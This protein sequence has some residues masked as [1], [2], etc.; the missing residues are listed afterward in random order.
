MNILLAPDKFKGTFSAN[1]VCQLMRQGLKKVLPQAHITSCPIADG[2]DGLLTPKG[3]L[4]DILVLL[5]HFGAT[6]KT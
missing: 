3:L 2:G 4:K 6:R 1:E 5:K